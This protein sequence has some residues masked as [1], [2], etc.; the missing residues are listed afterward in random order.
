MIA[1]GPRPRA[2]A[3]GGQGA[4]PALPLSAAQ[5]T[6]AK[7]DRYFSRWPLMQIKAAHEF[8]CLIRSIWLT[9]DELA[10]ARGIDQ[11]SARRM[12][13][14][15]HS[16][17]QKD[18]HGMSASM[19]CVPKASASGAPGTCRRVISADAGM[20]ADIARAISALLLE[21]AITGCS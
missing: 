15:S 8:R 2:P 20:S 9:Y 1:A 10:E 14:R 19:S 12:A 18:N 3:P 13:S 21:G 4:C 11:Q 6:T 16:R 7:L 17:R 5:T